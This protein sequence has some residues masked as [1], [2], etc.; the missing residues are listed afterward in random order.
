MGNTT[1]TNLDNEY[2]ETPLPMTS[3]E[4][5]LVKERW[6]DITNK[7]ELGMNIMIR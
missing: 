7:E 6:D 5:A 3:Q 2:K 4:I 1:N